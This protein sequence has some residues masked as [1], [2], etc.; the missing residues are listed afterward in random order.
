MQ[1]SPITLKYSNGS[2]TMVDKKYGT[3]LDYI[4]PDLKEIMS[5]FIYLQKPKN[6]DRSIHQ[7]IKMS[8]R[9]YLKQC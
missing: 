5:I 2:T 7:L 8:F 9:H 4:T 6:K 1:Y 3:Y